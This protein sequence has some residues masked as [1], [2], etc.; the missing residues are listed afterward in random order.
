[1]L[2]QLDAGISSDASRR[3]KKVNFNEQF[4]G[5]AEV[6]LN[7]RDV[8]GAFTR[9]GWA[10]MKENLAGMDKFFGGE[11]WVLGDYSAAKPDTARLQEELRARYTSDYIARWREFLRTTAVARWATAARSLPGRCAGITMQWARWR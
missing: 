6:V 5:S 2:C 10:A 8:A 4:P 7:N 3:A 11:R 1:M 9:L